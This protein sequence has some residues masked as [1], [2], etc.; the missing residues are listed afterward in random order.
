MTTTT[1]TLTL[2]D[3]TMM[4]TGF[5]FDNIHRN[6]MLRSKLLQQQHVS[7]LSS[8][9]NNNTTTTTT[10]IPAAKK[11]GTTIAGIVFADGVV[12]GADTRATNGTE[13]AETNCEKIHYLASNIYC[14]G[15]GTAADTEQTTAL[16]QSNL[17]LLHDQM[18]HSEPSRVITACTLLKRFLHRYQGHISA[19][20]VLG[21]CDMEGPHVY[22]IY[23]HGSTGK[24]PYT[25][26]GSGSLAAMAVFESQWRSQ[27]NETE[28]IALVQR[29]IGAGIFN[30]L[31]SGSNCDICIIRT[32]QT[33]S[34]HRNMV[35]PNETAP[36]RN[37]IH[38]S[39]RFSLPPGTTPLLHTTVQ[40]HMPT[41]KEQ[42]ASMEDTDDDTNNNE[43]VAMDVEG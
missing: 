7:S 26:M 9:A 42:F 38:H 24:L 22:Q 29:A 13:V 15:A 33:V 6:A 17:Q 1:T 20:L 14:C 40:K 30:D 2:D 12:L 27:M 36:L 35:T 11:T 39:G 16:V 37:A 23:P 21:G 41:M 31:G 34:Y 10:S 28:A 25:T 4:T 43:G 3:P 8:S 5:S 19:A 32:D 18:H